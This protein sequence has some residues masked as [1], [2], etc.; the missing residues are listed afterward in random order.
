M[1][2]LRSWTPRNTFEKSQINTQNEK[3]SANWGYYVS[4]CLQGHPIDLFLEI[5]VLLATFCWLGDLEKFICLSKERVAGKWTIQGIIGDLASRI[6]GM[7]LLSE[8]YPPLHTEWLSFAFRP[9]PFLPTP[10]PNTEGL[11]FVDDH[12]QTDLLPS[13]SGCR[14]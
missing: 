4:V 9:H 2:L 3:N 5:S 1:H 11:N 10:S 12:T 8:T 6:A 14:L 7:C 13:N